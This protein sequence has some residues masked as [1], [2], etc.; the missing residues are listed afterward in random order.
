MVALKHVSYVT[1]EEG[2]KKSVILKVTDF[3]RMREEI[4]DLEDALALEKAR[5]EAT[6]FKR[7]RDFVS[8]IQAK[9]K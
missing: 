8:G 2:K 4:E 3:E 1:D 9:K 7:W 6:G 5:K